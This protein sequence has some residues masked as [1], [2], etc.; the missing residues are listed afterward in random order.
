M[1]LP[2]FLIIGAMKC[3]TSTL[4]AQLAAHPEIFM[5]TPK[6][7][8]FFSDDAVFAQGLDW[9][10]ALFDTAPP[11]AI[12]GEAS[13][14]YTK[15]PTYPDCLDRLSA[16]LSAPKLIYLI[17]DP[18]ARAVSHYSH[19][20]SMGNLA[21]DIDLA[22]NSHPELIEYGR[23]GAQIA[24][25]VRRFGAGNIRVFSLEGVR[26]NPQAMLAEIGE[27]LGCNTPLVWQEDLQQM[28]ASA[29]RTR[30]FPLH[31]L[32][33][34]NRG[35]TWLRRTLVPQS[36]RNRIKTSR[37]LQAVPQFSPKNI[38]HLQGVFTK[39]YGQLMQMFPKAGHLAASYPF[40]AG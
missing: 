3:G 37:Q 25:Y 2:D 27:F 34:D 30:R 31:G 39:D 7:P 16:T 36:I 24:P 1:A 5:T 32:L 29:Q 8:N 35:A 23:F 4:Q 20:W 40:I 38:Q 13:T 26:Q 11:G 19:E 18:I 17:R 15:L 22:L 33:F 14:H 6:E 10:G 28:N 12:K 21:G 9:Y